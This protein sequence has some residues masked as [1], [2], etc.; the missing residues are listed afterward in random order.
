MCCTSEP[1]GKKKQDG[2]YS[3]RRVINPAA[4]FENLSVIVFYIRL[5]TSTNQF[6]H[7][8]VYMHVFALDILHTLVLPPYKEAILT[9][10]FI[11]KDIYKMNR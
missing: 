6:C 4:R 11:F 10:V 8:N 7:I 5:N 9:N 1:D 2:L 3:F